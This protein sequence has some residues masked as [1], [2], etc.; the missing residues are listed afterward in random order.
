MKFPSS[1]GYQLDNFHLY[2]VI[3]HEGGVRAVVDLAIE[4]D[5]PFLPA[6][7]G[8]NAIDLTVLG[9]CGREARWLGCMRG[10]VM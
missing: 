9:G 7:D 5:Q 4:K 8:A 3:S 10:L 1:T 6:G 2:Q